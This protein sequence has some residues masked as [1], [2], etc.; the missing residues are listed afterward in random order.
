MY[1]KEGSSFSKDMLTVD[2]TVKNM[3]NTIEKST[4]ADTGKFLKY[5]GQTEPW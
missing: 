5:D 4:L 3:I 1:L 2:F